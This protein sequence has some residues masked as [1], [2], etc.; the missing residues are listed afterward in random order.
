MGMMSAPLIQH[1]LVVETEFAFGRAREVGSHEDLPIDVRTQHIA[2]AILNPKTPAAGRRRGRTL[3]RHEQVDALDDIDKRFVL[4]IL[5]IRP[6]PR[7]RAR[8][9]YRDLR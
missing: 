2:C 7:R 9:L 5:D 4:P 1:E 3:C 8:C 6:P